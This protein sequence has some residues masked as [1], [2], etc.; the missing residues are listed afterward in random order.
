M[1]HTV[2]YSCT[3]FNTDIFQ[4]SIGKEYWKSSCDIFHEP[5][6][7]R[8]CSEATF[9]MAILDSHASELFSEIR[10]SVHTWA[11]GIFWG[12]LHFTFIYLI[13]SDA[14]PHG[15][16]YSHCHN[17]VRN[18]SMIKSPIRDPNGV[19]RSFGAEGCG[20]EFSMKKKW[21]KY[22]HRLRKIL[23][24][25]LVAKLFSPTHEMI[26]QQRHIRKHLQYVYWVIIAHKKRLY[27]W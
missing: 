7:F 18:S 11:W 9:V 15:V 14:K 4:A 27:I 25:S 21:Q 13:W 6:F 1:C 22:S 19:C 24:H 8:H 17:G 16:C 12:I 2:K 20:F 5:C 26:S 23:S 10:W 3:Y